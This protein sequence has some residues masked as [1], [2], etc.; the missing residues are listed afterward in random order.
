MAEI[1]SGLSRGDQQTHGEKKVALK[2]KE[3]LEDDVLVYGEAKII[4]DDYKREIHPDFV[5][6]DPKSGIL[7]LEVKDWKLDKIEKINANTATL[8]IEGEK[9]EAENPV[10]Q[11]RG[12]AH[13]IV[14]K[15]E[16]TRHKELVH[17]IGKHNGKLKIPYAF[18]AV[19][20]HISREELE[21]AAGNGFKEVLPEKNVIYKD[22]LDSDKKKFQDILREMFIYEYKNFH[23][24]K[25]DQIDCIRGVLYPEII[26]V[27]PQENRGGMTDD[28]KAEE[29]QENQKTKTIELPEMSG[30]NIC[31]MDKEQEK[32]ARRLQVGDRVI[33]GV[34]GSG[35]TLILLYRCRMLVEENRGSS[36]LVL[37]FNV[38]LAARLRELL[39]EYGVRDG[40][41]VHH[42]HGW[43]REQL[44]THKP[45]YELGLPG[46]GGKGS[47]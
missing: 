42:F 35:K 43:C 37:C 7:I 38:S 47:P 16:K 27:S 30:E 2:L 44:E 14:K 13:S 46:G 24:M 39:Q 34:A 40:I 18:G 31:V 8:V 36:V 25:Q 10:E 19:F 28:S 22:D 4:I 23:G 29:S 5:I 17:K 3:L 41:K 45:G 26:I 11:A 15:L 32:L 9:K 12:Y 20:V 1:I 6:L 21:Q 33:N